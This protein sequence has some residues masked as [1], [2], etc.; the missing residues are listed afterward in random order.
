MI[1]DEMPC[2]ICRK[3]VNKVRPGFMTG[4]VIGSH[5]PTPDSMIPK[6]CKVYHK[7]CEPA[8]LKEEHD[9][10]VKEHDATK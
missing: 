9:K 6:H 5:P 2:C 10:A 3:M 8:F 7:E 1:P 4:L